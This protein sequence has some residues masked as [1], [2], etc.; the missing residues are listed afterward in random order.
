MYSFG[1]ELRLIS[2]RLNRSGAMGDTGNADGSSDTQTNST[3]FF[4][5]YTWLSDGNT[6][7]RVPE[8]FCW[9]KGKDYM[10]LVVSGKRREKDMSL[11]GDRPDIRIGCGSLSSKAIQCTEGHG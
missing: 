3:V 4:K 11:L 9:P 5:S 7:H 6:F 1:A 10:G 8:G 2:V